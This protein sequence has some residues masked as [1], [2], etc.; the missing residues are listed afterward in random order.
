M[1]RFGLALV[2]AVVIGLAAAL[3]ARARLAEPQTLLGAMA[4]VVA[5]TTW[6]RF[7]SRGRHRDGPSHSRSA[8]A[9]RT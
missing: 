2:R 6:W 3:L 8:T 1:G 4:V 7:R 5:A 9:G